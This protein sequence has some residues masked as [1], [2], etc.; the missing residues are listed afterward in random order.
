MKLKL[1]TYLR[2]LSKVIG[3]LVLAVLG[4]NFAFPLPLDKTEIASAQVLDRYDGWMSAFPI[5]VSYT[6]LTLPT[7]Y[8]V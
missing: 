1:K 2:R 4:L 3:V 5:A 6:H 7:I 8:S